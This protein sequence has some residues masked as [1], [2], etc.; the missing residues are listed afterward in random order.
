MRYRPREPIWT[1]KKSNSNTASRFSQR[2][3]RAKKKEALAAPPALLFFPPFFRKLREQ[4]TN[5]FKSLVS[6]SSI[7][8]PGGQAIC[9]PPKMCKCKW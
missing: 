8:Q 7:P 4:I 1:E 9:L 3:A 6:Y 2:G 5:R